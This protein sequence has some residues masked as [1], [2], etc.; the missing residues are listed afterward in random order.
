VPTATRKCSYK[1]CSVGRFRREDGIIKGVNAWCNHDCQSKHALANLAKLRAKQDRA[2]R[3]SFKQRKVQFYTNDVARQKAL[4]QTVANK[5]CMLLDKGKPCISSGIP[6][7]GV[8][9]KRNASHFKS[10]GSNSF[11]RYSML[12]LHAATAHDNNF[13]SGNIEGYRQGLKERYG[14]WIVDY[15]DN[16]PRRKEWTCEELLELRRLYNEEI[17]HIQ[18][19]N[20]PTRPWRVLP[21]QEQA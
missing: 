7:D 2:E 15:L 3:Q 10:R 16:A 9:R 14:Q 13:K 17:R 12:N 20:P 18:A 8:P 5:L 4:T 21:E 11:L 6:D 19:G 1:L